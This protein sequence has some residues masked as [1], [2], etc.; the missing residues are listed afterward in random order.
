MCCAASQRGRGSRQRLFSRKGG[1]WSDHLVTGSK[2]N[3]VTMHYSCRSPSQHF[4]KPFFPNLSCLC[5]WIM[6][7][8]FFVVFFFCFLLLSDAK[9]MNF[10]SKSS[11]SEFTMAWKDKLKHYFLFPWPSALGIP[12]DA[13]PIC[14]NPNFSVLSEISRST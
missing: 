6:C 5:F 7:F 14:E 9:L 11:L 12:A 13:L 3:Q 10:E 2:E 1:P 4:P 8:G